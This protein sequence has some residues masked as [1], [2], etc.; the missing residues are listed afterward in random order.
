MATQN[1]DYTAYETAARK[2]CERCGSDPDSLVQGDSGGTL[3]FVRVKLWTTVAKQMQSL[4]LLREC[5]EQYGPNAT[6]GT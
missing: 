4:E 6:K 3:L 2:Y 1:T 5:I